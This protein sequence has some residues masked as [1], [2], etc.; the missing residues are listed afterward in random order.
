M[1][2]PE[3]LKCASAGP[4]GRVELPVGYSLEM[5]YGDLILKGPAPDPEDAAAEGAAGIRISL[6][7]KEEAEALTAPPPEGN[8]RRIFFDADTFGTAW[9]AE[10]GLPGVIELRTRKAGDFIRLKAG[11]RKLQDLL[12]DMKVPR[13]YRDS[14]P[15]IALGSE[16]LF[17]GGDRP[18]YSA[19]HPVT[20]T[21]KRVLYSEFMYE[22]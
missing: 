19:A 14:L 4:S 10:N 7:S 22:I 20:E 2:A 17:A 16:I 18:R 5:E 15:L 3:R 12:V 11:T 21:T 6:I 9:E 1:C 13:R 8:V